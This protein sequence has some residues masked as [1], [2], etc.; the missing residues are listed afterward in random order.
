MSNPYI[1]KLNTKYRKKNRPTD[2]IAF[3][4]PVEEKNSLLGDIY[5][6]V[7]QANK[8]IQKGE[9]LHLELKRLLIHGVLHILGYDHGKKMKAKEEYYFNNL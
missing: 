6:S 8:Q 3:A 9:T 5:I 1:R 4:L 7:E 2:V